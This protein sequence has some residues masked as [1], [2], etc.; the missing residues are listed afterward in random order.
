MPQFS[1]Y[2]LA[3]VFCAALEYLSFMLLQTKI[4]L[5]VANTLAYALGFTGSFLLNKYAVFP[6]NNGKTPQQLL[7]YCLLALFNYIIGMA[8]LVWLVQSAGLPAFAAKA[9]AMVTVVSWNFLMY[10]KVVYR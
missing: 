9:I 1:R 5:L 10:K 4:N 3:G 2:L 6:N 7:A 8:L